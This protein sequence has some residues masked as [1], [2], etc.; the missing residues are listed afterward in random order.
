MN[1]GEK[2]KQRTSSK[3]LDWVRWC[4]AVVLFLAENWEEFPKPPVANIVRNEPTADSI[5]TSAG[6][7]QE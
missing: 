6:A 3:T 2:I 5:P 1:Q 7:K 4:V